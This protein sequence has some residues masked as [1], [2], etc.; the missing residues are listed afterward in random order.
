[1]RVSRWILG[2]AASLALAGPAVAQPAGAP[3]GQLW[4]E[5]SVVAPEPELVRLN[6]A[7]TR[8]ADQLKPALVQIRVQRPTEE[9]DP[10]EG[11]RRALGSGFVI[12]PAGY[13]VTNAHV[14]ERSTSR[15]GAARRRAGGSTGT[16]VGRDRRV[17]LALVKIDAPEPLPVLPLGD[18]ERLAVGRARAGARPPLR[19]RA[20]RVARDREPEGRAAPGGRAGLR[21]HPDRRGRESRQ[22]GRA[23]GQH[24]RPGRRRQHHGR[25]Q[26]LDR[27]RD[28]DQPG[29]DAPPAAPRQGQGRVGMA[30]RAHRRDHRGERPGLRARRAARRGHRGRAAGAAG[31]SGRAPGEGRHPR[32]STARPS[33]ARGSSSASSRSRR[34]ERPCASRSG[35]TVRRRS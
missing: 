21:L 8:L 23:A 5:D 27:L 34:W 22:L 17:D 28:P 1:M 26:R 9:P 10:E 24:G 18:S 31:R 30:R 11:P 25:A 2:V 13:V 7:L 20:D 19:A 35:G 32:R 33:G 3:T 12:H 6:T 14:V 16:V 4:R 29:Q 15:P